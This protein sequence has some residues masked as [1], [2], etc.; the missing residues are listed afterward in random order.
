MSAED[1]AKLLVV[2]AVVVGGFA[3]GKAVVDHV[4][5]SRTSTYTSDEQED[6]FAS[7]HYWAAGFRPPARSRLDSA[8]SIA[9]A[10]AGIG[11]TLY[12]APQLIQEL[13]ALGR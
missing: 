9:A 1:N 2:G 5:D 8:V 4:L 13:K 3:L 11:Y 6:D 12:Q 10:I 7:A